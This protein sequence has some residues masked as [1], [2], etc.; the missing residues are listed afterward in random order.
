ML[1]SDPRI[2]RYRKKEKKS[3]KSAP[4][5]AT[6]EDELLVQSMFEWIVCNYDLLFMLINCF[7]LIHN[8]IIDFCCYTNEMQSIY[9]FFSFQ[10]NDFMGEL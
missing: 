10:V 7:F 5:T 6:N 3:K 1:D 8:Q 9:I 2:R 4:A